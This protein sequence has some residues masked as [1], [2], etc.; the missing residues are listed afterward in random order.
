[1]TYRP[2]MKAILALAFARATPGTPNTPCT[3]PLLGCTQAGFRMG[4]SGE[5]GLPR[6]PVDRPIDPRRS[7][8]ALGFHLWSGLSLQALLVPGAQREFYRYSRNRPPAT[9]GTMPRSRATGSQDS[10]LTIIA[11]TRAQAARLFAST[12]L[13]RTTE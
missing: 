7:G 9:K 4:E 2:H 12:Q 8:R 6:R 1:M 3:A 5:R 13:D 11:V 10:R